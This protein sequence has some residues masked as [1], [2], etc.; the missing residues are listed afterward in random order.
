MP[1]QYKSIKFNGVRIFGQGYGEDAYFNSKG[2]KMEDG[3]TGMKKVS[4][5]NVYITSNTDNLYGL[6][7]EA[8]N[9]LIENQYRSLDYLF[10]DLFVAYKDGVGLGVIT[11]DNE[12]KLD[13]DYNVISKIGDKKLLKGVKMSTKGDVTTI[14]N[15]KLE[16]ITR[17]SSVDTVIFDNYIEIYNDE[18]DIFIDNDGVL[19]EKDEC[20]LALP[21]VLDKYYKSYK[22]NG[23]V[24]YSVEIEEEDTEETENV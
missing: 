11:K 19:K 2:E 18:V 22:E 17:V 24:Y 4:E 6:T 13:F 23:E 12:V 10:D 15:A 21:R 5:L 16:E 8:G 3:I 9:V 7:D 14:F 20:A 1:L